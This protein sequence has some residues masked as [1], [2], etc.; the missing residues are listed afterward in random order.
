[1]NAELTV[2]GIEFHI[3]YTVNGGVGYYSNPDDDDIEI[4]SVKV[5]GNNQDLM[6]VIDSTTLYRIEKAIRVYHEEERQDKNE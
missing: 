5:Y 4:D 3:G 1:M 2:E 6:N